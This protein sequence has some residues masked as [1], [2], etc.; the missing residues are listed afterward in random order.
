[1]LEWNNSRDNIVS[2]VNVYVKYACFVVKMAHF[3]ERPL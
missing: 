3:K 2:N 1:M